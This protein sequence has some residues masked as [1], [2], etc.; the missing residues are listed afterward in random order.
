M[1]KTAIYCRLAYADNTAIE[2]Q[3][4]TLEQFAIEQGYNEFTVYIDNGASGSTFDRPA[5][6]K[7]E[8]AVENGE[9]DT[10]ICRDISRISRSY[11]HITPWLSKIKKLGVKLITVL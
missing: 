10:L 8:K 4:K 7:L 3:R 5:F 6:Q 9:H 11:L 1:K 2:N